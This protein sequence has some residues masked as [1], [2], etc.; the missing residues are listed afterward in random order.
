MKTQRRNLLKMIIPVT[1]LVTV[2]IVVAS[3]AIKN[4]ASTGSL[5]NPDV[6]SPFIVFA[7]GFSTLLEVGY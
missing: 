1:I 5:T 4:I 2:V 6:Y 3:I 7:P